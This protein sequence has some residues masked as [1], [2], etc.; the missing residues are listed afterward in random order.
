[1]EG[2]TIVRPDNVTVVDVNGAGSPF[3]GGPDNCPARLPGSY[4]TIPDTC[5]LQWRAGQLSGQTEHAIDEAV[6]PTQPSMEGRTI[7]RPDLLA[8]R[9]RTGTGQSLQWRAGQLS[10]QTVDHDE[11]L[12]LSYDPSMEGRTIVRPDGRWSRCRRVLVATFNG[13][14]D[15][16]PARPCECRQ[17]PQRLPSFNGGPD[18]CPA[19]RRT[20]RLVP[21]R[22]HPF[23]GGP[24]NCPA[25]PVS[26]T[27]VGANGSTFNGG[28]D[29][30]PARPRSQQRLCSRRHSFNGG[31]DNCP[32]RQEESKVYHPRILS[33]NGGP[34]NCPARP[35]DYRATQP[36]NAPL[37]WRAG[38]LSG[39]TELVH[40][41]RTGGDVPSMEGR[42]IV[43]PDTT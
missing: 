42:T 1:M 36:R 38:Q 14:P 22:T 41:V 13:G 12:N 17:H 15:N 29:N 34:D 21:S 2:R 39:Q 4:E 18:N 32:A 23:N 20:P 28:P 24:D 27:L 43:R 37:Q 40:V 16:C 3:N 7:V 5:C 11:K 30:C 8:G 25:R 35:P 26:H 9:H 10:G 33:F 31:P 19:R 6:D